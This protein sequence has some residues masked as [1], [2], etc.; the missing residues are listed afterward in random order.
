MILPIIGI[1]Q[2]IIV[3]AL[4]VTAMG[5]GAVSLIQAVDAGLQQYYGIGLHQ[6]F[7]TL[8]QHQADTIGV[9]QLEWSV[10]WNDTQIGRFERLFANLQ[11]GFVIPADS[12]EMK[13]LLED[14]ERAFK[15]YYDA[16]GQASGGGS[17]G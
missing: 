8:T 16:D 1:A 11:F 14:G 13:A 9:N 4:G 12:A 2:A 5:A 15:K 17:E 6:Q 7:F 10:A 3:P